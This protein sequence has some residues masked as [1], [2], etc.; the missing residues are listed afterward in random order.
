MFKCESMISYVRDQGIV[1]IQL[2]EFGPKGTL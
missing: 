2:K 1:G